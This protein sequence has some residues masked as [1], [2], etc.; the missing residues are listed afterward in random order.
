M[1]KV[2]SKP[3]TEFWREN[4]QHHVIYPKSRFAGSAVSNAARAGPL[5][6]RG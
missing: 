2:L 6:R 5:A 4:G 3:L 1:T